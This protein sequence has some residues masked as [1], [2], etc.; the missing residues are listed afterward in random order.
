MACA[1]ADWGDLISHHA[2]RLHSLAIVSP[3]LNQGIPAAASGADF[4]S[5]V[6]AGAEGASA[7]RAKALAGQLNRS[8]FELLSGY[9][10]PIWA[11][12]VADRIDEIERNLLAFWDGVGETSVTPSKPIPEGAGEVSGIHY[13]I[14]GHGPPIVLLLLSL[15]PSQWGALD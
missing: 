7:E 3:H 12:T 11:D 14:V 8:S 9:E 1:S 5:L 6:I 15:A 4:P 2:N 10:S 13:R